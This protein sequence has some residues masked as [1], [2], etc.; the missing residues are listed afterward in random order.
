[1]SRNPC[2]NGYW[3]VRML[4][5]DGSV[6]T[7]WAWAKSNRTPSLARRSRA[8]VRAR[9][10]YAPRASARSV[11]MVTSRM[12]WWAIGRKS[13]CTAGR[14]IANAA[15]ARAATS[16]AA[17]PARP[18]R[19]R[20]RLSRFAAPP[21][22]SFRWPPINSFYCCARAIVSRS[23]RWVPIQASVVSNASPSAC[24][25]VPRPPPP[26]SREGMPRL[27]G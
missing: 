18:H 5:C 23:A 16:T 21:G 14:S 7:A 15:A 13:A 25:S 27:T 3:P 20:R 10:P 22:R 4:A 9:P 11:S 19:G 12:F 17:T 1:M 8:G 2:W 24:T 6:T 26:M